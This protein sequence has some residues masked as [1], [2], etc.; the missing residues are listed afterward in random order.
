MS[1]DGSK[2]QIVQ[3][4]LRELFYASFLGLLIFV[5]AEFTKPGIVSNYLNL[6][7]FLIIVLVIFIADL[8]ATDY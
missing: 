7:L 3:I 5:V 4:I 6:N 8:L 2:K 1:I